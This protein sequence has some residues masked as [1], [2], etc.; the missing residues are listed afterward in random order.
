MQATVKVLWM[1]PAL[2]ILFLLFFGVVAVKHWLYSWGLL[3]P[4]FMTGETAPIMP[5]LIH[6]AHAACTYPSPLSNACTLTVCQPAH[7][8]LSKA[9]QGW[10]CVHLSRQLVWLGWL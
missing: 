6:H 10:L 1:M 8:L 9:V 5:A 2:Q 3:L 4:C 7:A